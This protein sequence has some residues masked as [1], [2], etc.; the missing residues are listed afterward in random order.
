LIFRDSTVFVYA[1][2]VDYPEHEPCLEEIK[3]QIVSDE[4]MVNVIVLSECYHILSVR[5]KLS[6]SDVMYRLESLLKSRRTSYVPIVADTFINAMKISKRFNIRI[7]DALIC[8][9]MRENSVKRLLTTNEKHFK[10]IPWIE[11]VNPLSRS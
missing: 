2:I 8:A 6:K 11:V 10:K 4:I 7:N 1:N 9:C 5:H 3:N